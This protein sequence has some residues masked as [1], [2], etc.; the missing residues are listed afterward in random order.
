MLPVTYDVNA[1]NNFINTGQW[2]DG[3]TMFDINGVPE[4]QVYPSIKDSGNFGQISL[5]DSHVGDSTE[6]SWVDN[7]VSASDLAALQSANLIPLSQHNPNSWDWQGD[8]GFKA[9]L[10]MDINSYPGKTF[11]I[12]LFTPYNASSAN[13]QAGSGNG[14]NYYFNIVQFVGITIMPGGGNRQII[15]EP[16]AVSVPSFVLSGAPAPAGTTSS[17]VTTFTYPRLTN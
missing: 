3:T 11:I 16:A 14:S 12:P 5:D 4:L 7:G 6:I 15:I 17:T 8:T 9:S 1:W 10:V 13:Y 2:P